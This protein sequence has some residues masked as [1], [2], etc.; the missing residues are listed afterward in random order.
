MKLYELNP[1]TF[2]RLMDNPQV[3]VDAAEGNPDLLYKLKNIDGMY[4]YVI[5]SDKQVY[6]FAAWTEVTPA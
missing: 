4:S 2:F 5:G 6:H 1:N 3:P